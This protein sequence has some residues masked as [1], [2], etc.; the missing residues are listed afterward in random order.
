MRNM[1]N[2]LIVLALAAAITGIS[3][4]ANDNDQSRENAELKQKVEQLDKEVEE[5]K[6]IV[7]NQ[8]GTPTD[9]PEKKFVWSNLDI[10]L[11]GKVKL[12][13]SY[14][15][16]RTD[17]GNFARW[18]E[19]ENLNPNDEQFN[20]TAN[21]T[22]L[23]ML[24]NGPDDGN[25]K[26]S[27]RVEIDFYGGGDE[28]KSHLM[29][30][31]AYMKMD[32]PNK[33]FNIIAGQTSDVISPL[34]PSTLNYSVF[35]W[36][37]NIGYRRPQI[38]LTKEYTVKNNVDLKLECALART[39]GRTNTP[40]PV[41]FRTD[42]GEDAGFPSVQARFGVT[43]PVFGKKK[44]TI[45]VSAHWGQ[46]EYDIAING[47]GANKKFLSWSLNMDLN[48]PVNDKCTIKAEVF[49]GENLSA[50]LGG[51]GQGVT[52]TA[53]IN[54]YEEIGSSGGWIAAGFGPWGKFSYNIGVGMDDVKKGNVQISN[55]T[56][57]RC[58]FANAI[59]A[60]NKHTDIGLELSH[61]RTEYYGN[62]D[63]ESLRAQ[64]SFIYKF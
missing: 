51:I 38:R 46:E 12:D 9:S 56:M 25:L 20:M 28:N 21:E 4:A 37:G 42:S 24:I 18:V 50:Y 60:A 55:K 15:S 52:T 17:V 14:D 63:A 61:W 16:S 64:L 5:L 57:N 29:M 40:L 48:Q 3:Y 13:A 6:K 62:G 53:G 43:L 11:Y 22:R 30:R 19:P 26:T 8:I 33:R 41:A 2:L 59:Y 35:W 23:G 58:V 32:W 27:G 10:Q 45:G 54:Q 1:V 47:T 39:I 7:A 49:T 34:V 44:T 36:V 31:H